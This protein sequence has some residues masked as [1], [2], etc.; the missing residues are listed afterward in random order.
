MSMLV[1]R[2]RKRIK[3]LEISA[4]EASLAAGLNSNAIGD[5][6]RGKT[7]SPRTHNLYAIASVLHCDVDYLLGKSDEAAKDHTPKH[8]LCYITLSNEELELVSTYRR[9]QKLDKSKELISKS[10]ELLEAINAS[11]IKSTL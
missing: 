9:L 11:S 8:N 7:K 5:I 4:T 1:E 10:R 2:I 6:L 3:E